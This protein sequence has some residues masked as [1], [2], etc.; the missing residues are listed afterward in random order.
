MASAASGI[1]LPHWPLNSPPGPVHLNCPF[2]EPLVG[3][4]GSGV[5][6]EP[7]CGRAD[8]RGGVAMRW[9][10]PDE[11]LLRFLG[12]GSGGSS[13]VGRAEQAPVSAG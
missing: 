12:S 2:R 7:P 8:D 11:V 4:D 9:Q 5:A 3:P 6:M 1:C 10:P 13:S